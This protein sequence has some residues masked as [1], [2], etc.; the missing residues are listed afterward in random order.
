MRGFR[1]ILVLMILCFHCVSVYAGAEVSL[2]ALAMI[3]SSNKPWKFN[4]KTKATGLFQIT[5]IALKDFNNEVGSSLKLKDMY[6][7]EKN[8]HVA[9]WTLE[10]RIPQ[11]IKVYKLK[12]DL[13]T[14]IAI[15]NWGIDNTINWH[16]SGAKFRELPLETR[17]F[18]KKYKRITGV[19]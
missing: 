1:G 16:R 8:A 14:R 3:E 19:K 10:E 13:L 9:I 5:P 7:E 18:Y 12:D 2:D 11:F 17:N 6:I 15:W 4:P